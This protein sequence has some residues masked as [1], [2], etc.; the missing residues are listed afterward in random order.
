MNAGDQTVRAAV[1]PAPLVTEVR[2]F[3]LPPVGPDDGLLEVEA[4]GLCGTDWDFYTRRRGAHLGALILGHEIVGRVAVVGERA[5]ARWGVAEGDRVAVE[6]FLPCGHCEF[7][8]SGRPA[9]CEATDSRSQRPFLRYGATPIDVPPALWGGFSEVL[10]LHPRALVHRLPPDLSA[11]LATLFV[12]ISNGIRWV[13]KEGRLPRGGTVVVIGPGAH[14]LGC[15]VAAHEGGAGRVIA[16]GRAHSPRLDAAR[17]LGAVALEALGADLVAAVR[18]VTDGAMADVVVDLAPG[19]SDTVEVA[20]QIARKGAT[21]ILASSKHGRPIAGFQS[22]LVVRKEL[23]VR[24]VRGRD[25]QSVE[26]ALRILG[27]RRYPLERLRT[28]TFLL[29]QA[30]QALRVLG[31]RTDPSSIHVAV[32]P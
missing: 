12:P 31:E 26:E 32:V 25:P 29:T 6:E 9:L 11:D 24:G 3:R 15:V 5:A 18:E 2:A 20:L 16:V 19:S 10:Y 17:A 13:R 28:H 21:V 4:C 8:I 1:T 27:S 30:D 14:G 22:D 23:T 7:C